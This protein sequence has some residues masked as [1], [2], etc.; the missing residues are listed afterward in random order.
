MSVR[1]RIILVLLDGE[2]HSQMAIINRLRHTIDP[3]WAVR[4]RAQYIDDSRERNRKR[5]NV[6]GR[7]VEST[8]INESAVENIKS[9]STDDAVEW[10]IT[11][12]IRTAA[13]DSAYC[14]NRD[15]DK[16][17]FGP[18][19]ESKTTDGVIY[20]HLRDATR[21]AMI[22]NFQLCGKIAAELRDN[23]AIRGTVL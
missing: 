9:M 15:S 22:G 11:N 6:S 18:V 12:D 2:W 8:R 13:H 23:L 20:W 10:V 21:K 17:E 4:K 16:E 3:S 1:H 5:P 19:I 14:F 7:I